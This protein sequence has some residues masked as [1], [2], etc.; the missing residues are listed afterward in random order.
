MENV[1]CLLF[2][3]AIS[4]LVSVSEILK[5][6]NLAVEKSELPD[7]FPTHVSIGSSHNPSVFC[8]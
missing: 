7:W 1:A 5:K 8:N 4:T 2:I 6:D 3:A